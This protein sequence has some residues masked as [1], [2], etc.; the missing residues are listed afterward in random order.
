MVYA[1]KLAIVYSAGMKKDNFCSIYGVRIA[2][3]GECESRNPYTIVEPEYKIYM[4]KLR[5]I[6]SRS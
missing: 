5:E 1:F 4:E 3:L 2:L 6:R